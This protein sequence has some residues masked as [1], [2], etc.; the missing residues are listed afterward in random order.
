MSWKKSLL[1]FFLLVFFLGFAPVEGVWAAPEPEKAK[2]EIRIKAPGA[3]ETTAE[4]AVLMEPVTGRLI[5]EKE[6]HKRLPMASVTKHR[7][8]KPR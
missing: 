7:V 6:A 4:A 2:E 1:L 8:R 5:Y 3:P